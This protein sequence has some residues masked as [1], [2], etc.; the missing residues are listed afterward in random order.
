LLV[1]QPAIRQSADPDI[2]MYW[3]SGNPG[4]LC[5]TV[6]VSANDGSSGLRINEIQIAKLSPGFSNQ[7]L[8]RYSLNFMC[9]EKV[10]QVNNRFV[11]QNDHYCIPILEIRW[12]ADRVA[13][14]ARSEDLRKRAQ[15]SLKKFTDVESIFRLRFV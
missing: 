14:G 1:F 8:N 15:I 3:L 10:K 7:S 2:S 13:G 11:S 9:N 12:A 4:L 5:L 6:S